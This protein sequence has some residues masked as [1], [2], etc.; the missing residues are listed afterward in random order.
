MNRII[1]ILALV[2]SVGN[3]FGQF[4]GAAGTAGSTA[5]HQDSS[6]F[7]GW[8]TDGDARVGYLDIANKSL[9][10]VVNGTV[11]STL[12]KPGIEVL[13]LGDSGYA[14]LTFEAT[15]CDGPGFDFAVFEN[16]FS[17]YFLELA[18]VEVSSDGNH[19]V[20]FP[21]TSLM[22]DSVQIGPWDESSD[23]TTINN[24]AGKYRAQFGTPFDL[25]ELSDSSILD[26]QKVSHVR[27]VDAIGSI[28]EASASFDQYGNVINDPY[29]TDFDFGGFDLNAVGVIHQNPL[30]TPRLVIREQLI[31]PN[32]VS[33]NQPIRL[34]NAFDKLLI[35]NIHGVLIDEFQYDSEFSAPLRSGHYFVKA[36]ANSAWTTRKLIV[37]E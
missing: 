31:L 30:G 29:P 19:F 1:Y 34:A 28:S 5:I 32:P 22:Q 35:F 8:A 11:S 15:I 26:I 17:D 9:G 16:A 36:F 24:L 33:S 27:I 12:G 20:R 3:L 7:I 23:P 13:S 37:I 4:P 21:A 14:T 25:S 10:N 6:I 18:F 2:F